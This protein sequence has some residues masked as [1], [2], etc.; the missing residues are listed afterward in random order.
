M[1]VLY[2]GPNGQHDEEGGFIMDEVLTPCELSEITT[3]LL[4]HHRLKATL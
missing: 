3:P 2:A 1:H 4:K